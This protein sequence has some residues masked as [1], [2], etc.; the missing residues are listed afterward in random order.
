MTGLAIIWRGL[1]FLNAP[2]IAGIKIAGSVIVVEERLRVVFGPE[3][4][5]NE[6]MEDPQ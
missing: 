3:T 6:L 1:S 5:E 2:P 4:A